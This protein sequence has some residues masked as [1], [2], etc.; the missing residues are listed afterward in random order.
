MP[1][2]AVLTISDRS[3]AGTQ[4]DTSGAIAVALL[5]GA[6]T[7][8]E[9]HAE[10]VP[11]DRPLIEQTLRRWVD[12]EGYNLVITS[13]GTG[14]SPRDVTPQATLNVATYEVPGL[15]ELMRTVS[16]QKTPMAAL[17]RAVAVVRARSLIIN[18]PGS[19]KGVREC[20]EAI[21]PILPHALEQLAS[22]AGHPR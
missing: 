13:G 22:G 5:T 16:L 19:P 21:L 3:F 4:E 10:I 7:L 20:L 2:V 11:D 17:S 12:D 8:D 6:L 15:A 14:I 18:L 1:R 9:V